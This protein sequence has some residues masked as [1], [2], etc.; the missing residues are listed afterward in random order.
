VGGR[1]ETEGS[2]Y[3]LHLSVMKNDRFRAPTELTQHS[4][5]RGNSHWRSGADSHII[6]GLAILLAYPS[7]EEGGLLIIQMISISLRG[8][9]VK[10]SVVCTHL[11]C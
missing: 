4:A 1:G 10:N 8:V 3:T 2:E 5:Y 11:S 9:G 6:D 7:G